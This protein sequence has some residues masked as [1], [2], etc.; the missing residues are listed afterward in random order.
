MITDI[1]KNATPEQLLLWKIAKSKV[2]YNSITEMS[3][4]GAI[5][6]SEFETYAANKLYI[7]LQ[8]I[9]AT[10]A[11]ASLTNS[12]VSL[13]NEANAFVLALSNSS[14]NYNAAH[15]YNPCNMIIPNIWFSKIFVSG[16]STMQ[17]TGYKLLP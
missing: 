12:Y 6:G 16:Y 1:W 9:F 2:A 17:F 15:Y 14:I 11:G 5:A 10:S 13:Y 4:I 7:A 8:V 3:F